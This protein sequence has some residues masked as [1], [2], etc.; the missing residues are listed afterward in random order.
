MVLV[1]ALGG[2]LITI[3]LAATRRRRTALS[4]ALG[5]LIL[6][7][8]TLSGLQYEQDRVVSTTGEIVTGTTTSVLC[9]TYPR[10]AGGPLAVL[11]DAQ[12][13]QCL[14]DRRDVRGEAPRPGEPVVVTWV[15]RPATD[16][17][18]GVVLDLAP[19]TDQ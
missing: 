4:L 7:L 11:S 10:F 8:W 5:L 13:R 18:A 16:G 14:S 12:D 15:P 19:A 3:G 6:T 9:F 17:S 1:F 2:L